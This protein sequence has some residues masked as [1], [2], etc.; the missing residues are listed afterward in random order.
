EPV[1]ARARLG[2]DRDPR[3]VGSFAPRR[4]PVGGG[5][6]SAQTFLLNPQNGAV[7]EGKPPSRLGHY[8]IA[9]FMLP[10]VVAG[11]YLAA[12]AIAGGCFWLAF[13]RTGVRAEAVVT[14]LWIQKGGDSDVHHV[15]YEY[16]LHPTD[17]R[18]IQ[19]RDTVSEDFYG[20]LM[21]GR[22]VTVRYLAG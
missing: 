19:G 20:Q 17:D 4:E 11:V 14:K 22:P 2:P 16:G 5:S 1:A 12:I 9:V 10:F 21:V 3:R 15:A 18:T 8:L 13:E 6:M 7:P